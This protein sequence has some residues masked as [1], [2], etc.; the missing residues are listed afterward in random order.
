MVVLSPMPAD[1][2]DADL[3]L[4]Q[5]NARSAAW[6]VLVAPLPVAQKTALLESAA[7]SGRPVLLIDPQ[8]EAEADQA[9]QLALEAPPTQ[10]TCSELLAAEAGEQSWFLYNDRRWNGTVPPE[11]LLPHWPNLRLE[12]QKL[13]PTRRLDVVLSTWLQQ[14]EVDCSQPGFLWLLA[15]QAPQVLAGAGVF[16]ERLATIRLEGAAAKD[17]LDA[18]LV[19]R[20]V[21]SCHRL[22]CDGP[23]HQLWRLDGQRLLERE[24]LLVSQQREGLQV[25]VEELERE[26]SAQGAEQSRQR[27]LLLMSAQELQGQYTALSMERD[28]LLQ[29]REALKN[30]VH[31]QQERFDRINIELDEILA[32]IDQDRSDAQ[33]SREMD[34]ENV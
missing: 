12:G 6:L 11:D 9:T 30:Q 4:L 23:N 3:D 24:L 14:V 15:T 26:L 32:L 1:C 19:D 22:E 25:R 13:R 31:E 7:A 17:G 10:L 8:L 16:L 20:L 27:E 2:P 21:A 33:E 34:A 29:S 28:Q 18:E 5:A